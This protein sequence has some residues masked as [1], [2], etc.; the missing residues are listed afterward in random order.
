MEHMGKLMGEEKEIEILRSHKKGGMARREGV[1]ADRVVRKNGC[2]TVGDIVIGHKDN[3]DRGLR[4]HPLKPSEKVVTL[5][6]NR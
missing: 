1:K 4:L 2:K 3:D 5:M 6:G